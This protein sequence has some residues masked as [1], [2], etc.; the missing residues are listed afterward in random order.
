MT[1]S[2]NSSTSGC[3]HLDCDTAIYNFL[4]EQTI[5]SRNSTTFE[6]HVFFIILINELSCFSYEK[7]YAI[8]NKYGYI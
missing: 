1:D 8:V 4:Y 6:T 5:F 3:I 2:W 7:I